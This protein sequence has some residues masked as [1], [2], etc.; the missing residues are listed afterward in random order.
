MTCNCKNSGTQS[1]CCTG[2]NTCEKTCIDV[3]KVFDACM[4]QYNDTLTFTTEQ[5]FQTITSVV[6][7]GPS[8]IEALTITPIPDTPNSRVQGT[9]T[10]PVTI[11]GTDATGGTI[12]ETTT[13]EFDFDIVMRVPQDGVISPQIIANVVINGVQN[14]ICDNTV[15]SNACITIIIKVVANVILIVPTYGYPTIPPCQEY[16]QDICSGLFS[17][18]VFPR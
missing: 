15:T 2:N 14:T 17:A 1:L 13:A 10:T 4:Q 7:S 16:T 5:T 6:S 3:N 11:T 9:V 18:P 12:T 8:T